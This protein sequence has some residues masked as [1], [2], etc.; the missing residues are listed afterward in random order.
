MK[1]IGITGGTGFVGV[2]LTRLLVEKGYN[3]IVFTRSIT[4]PASKKGVTYVSWN[5]EKSTIDLVALKKIDAVVHLA[6]TGISDQRWTQQRKKEILNSRIKSTEFLVAQLKEHCRYCE[7]FV[8]ASAAC[9]YGPDQPGG[10]PFK[11]DNPAFNDFLGN[12]CQ[13]WEA[14]ALKAANLMY[15]TILRFGL[16]LGKNGGVLP[17]YGQHIDF[18]IMPVLGYGNQVI[19][20]I[21]VTDLCRMILFALENDTVYGIYN[22]VS[23]MPVTHKTL[24][25]VIA[26]ANGIV[27]K[28]SP[29]PAFMLKILMGELSAELLKSCNV[30]AQKIIDAGFVF[31]HPQIEDAMKSITCI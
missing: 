31:Q 24:M 23:P 4:L 2:S 11:E 12:T 13:Q 18:G 21:E 28:P 10:A 22:A 30:S 8:S 9:I 15:T 19:S 29:A 14:N 27:K 5:P 16:V 1:V 7:R 26:N 6:G 3:V 20:W 25:K 17:Q